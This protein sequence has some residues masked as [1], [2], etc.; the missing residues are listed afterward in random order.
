MGDGAHAAALWSE[1]EVRA[2]ERHRYV[3]KIEIHFEIA[4]GEKISTKTDRG[5]DQSREPWTLG[6][7]RERQALNLSVYVEL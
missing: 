6:N 1:D 4:S 2:Q 5:R 3:R 7:P